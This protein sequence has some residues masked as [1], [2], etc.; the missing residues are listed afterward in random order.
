MQWK[1]VAATYLNVKKQQ[2]KNTTWL[3]NPENVSRASISIVVTAQIRATFLIDNVSKIV[4]DK[5]VAQIWAGW[6]WPWIRRQQNQLVSCCCCC[7]NKPKRMWFIV[8]FIFISFIWRGKVYQGPKGSWDIIAHSV[9]FDRWV[10]QPPRLPAGSAVRQTLFSHL[11]NI[12]GMWQDN[13]S[14]L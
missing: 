1:S 7:N 3:R 11:L 5:K 8:V 14:P 9:Q 13:R 2:K 12:C 4:I 10:S 6:M